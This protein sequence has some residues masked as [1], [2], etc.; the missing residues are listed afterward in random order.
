MTDCLN[1]SETF[2]FEKQM[3]VGLYFSKPILNKVSQML[4]RPFQT[5]HPMVGEK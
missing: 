1:Q 2:E 4:P 3:S 5:H